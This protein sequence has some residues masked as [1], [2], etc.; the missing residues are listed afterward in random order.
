VIVVDSNI[1]CYYALPGTR[2]A[3]A[4]RLRARDREWC[5][6]TLWRSEFRNVVVGQIRRGAMDLAAA[7][8]VVA[9]TEAMLRDNEFTVDSSVVL[10]RAAESGCTAYD[11]EYVVL[12]EH[13]G[14]P[15]VTSDKQVLAAFP[16]RAVSL[17]QYTA[18]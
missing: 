17:E 6:P 2:T 15:L 3:L 8:E 1:L 18:Q 11:C 9:L 13:L 4:D 14:V 16:A 7:Q 10:A 5:V 12:A